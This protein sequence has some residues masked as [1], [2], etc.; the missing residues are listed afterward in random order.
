MIQN[1]IHL[2]EFCGLSLNILLFLLFKVNNG[3]NT[4][5]IKAYYFK[6]LIIYNSLFCTSDIVL[7]AMNNMQISGIPYVITNL[8]DSI[9]RIWMLQY[10]I[11]YITSL[12][13][14]HAKEIKTSEK[15][16][17]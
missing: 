13:P 7:S 9:V 2:T 1:Y 8:I 12:M 5:N 4:K 17:A 6:K 14:V 3:D 16:F 10:V 11:L 15:K